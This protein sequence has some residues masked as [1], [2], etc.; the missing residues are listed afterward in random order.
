MY[1]GTHV[2][3]LVELQSGDRLTVMQPNVPRT[4]PSE[5][6]PIYVSWDEHE[7]VALPVE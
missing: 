6:T 3:Y 5:D 1:L 7:C 2:H 4:L